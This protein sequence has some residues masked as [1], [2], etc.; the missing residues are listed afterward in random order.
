MIVLGR[1]LAPYGVRGA[2]KLQVYADAPASWCAL[3]HWRLSADSEAGDADWRECELQQAS[4]HNK[5]VL[6]KLA[7][8]EDR[9]AAARLSGC[10]VGVPRAALPAT[11]KD[12]YYWADL[13]GLDVVNEDGD[14]LGRVS[15]LLESGANTVLCVGSGKEQRLLPFVAQVV[16]QVDV[17]GGVVRVAWGK[18]W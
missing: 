10:Y 13:V 18:D 9:D 11:A 7:G 12:E 4:V 15:S 6:A 8:V 5:V 14:S 3:P 2:V 16:K 17:A 1:I